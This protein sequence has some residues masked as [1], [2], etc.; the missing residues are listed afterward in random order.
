MN[1]KRYITINIPD[2][3]HRDLTMLK[4]GFAYKDRQKYSMGKTIRRI[5][6]TARIYDKDAV[7]ILDNNA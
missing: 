2:D 5:I 4:I 7:S 6:E 1:K 3:V